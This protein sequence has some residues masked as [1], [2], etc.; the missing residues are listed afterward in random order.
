MFINT[1]ETRM[2]ALAP[3]KLG[4]NP[5]IEERMRAFGLD[6]AELA[7]R[8]SLSRNSRAA[9]E[10]SRLALALLSPSDV[11][12]AEPMA[13]AAMMFESNSYIADEVCPIQRVSDR[14]GIY[15][16]YDRDQARS[17]IETRVGPMSKS[18]EISP[19][20]STGTYLVEDHSLQDVVAAVTDNANPSLRLRASAA[21]RIAD[22]LA[23]MR[24]YRVSTLLGT[25]ANY[26]AA[27]QFPLGGAYKWNGGGSADPVKDML[28]AIE[29]MRVDCTHAVMSDIVWHAAQQNSAI[30]TILASQFDNK[31]LLRTQDF[32]L[33]FGIPN[34]MITKAEYENSAGARKRIW[35]EADLVLLNVN[36][37]PDA[38]T[39]ARTFR[40]NQGAGGFVA[41]SWIDPEM[42]PSGTHKAKISHADDEA[43]IASD[44]GAIITGVK[45]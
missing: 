9:R 26:A 6:P 15:Y 4:I 11:T 13:Q 39:F 3:T 14:T 29:A 23:M 17:L 42:G 22:R 7:N 38:R 28:A 25:A 20:I 19:D 40:L 45:Q 37:A 34:V 33:Y 12:T 1:T 36:D 16:K 8:V 27:N 2:R 24:E 5:A 10:R 18:K 31:G 32:G 35:S 30:K 41:S 21:V 43:I 44:Y